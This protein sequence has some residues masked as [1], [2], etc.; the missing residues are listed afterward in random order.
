MPVL[1]LIISAVEVTLVLAQG[2]K[3]I[4]VI[5]NEG[6]RATHPG[7]ISHSQSAFG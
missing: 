4:L 1:G 6:T 7:N 3:V 2:T 5:T